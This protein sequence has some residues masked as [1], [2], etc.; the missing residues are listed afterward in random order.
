MGA[1]A[2]TFIPEGQAL[3]DNDYRQLSNENL[4]GILRGLPRRPLMASEEDARLSLSGLLKNSATLYF[5][6]T[7]HIVIVLFFL[8]S[9]FL[10]IK[11]LSFRTKPMPLKTVRSIH[12]V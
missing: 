10:S 12:Y 9:D 7:L 8:D 4:A 3:P 5:L 1:N 2:V 6:F 11:D